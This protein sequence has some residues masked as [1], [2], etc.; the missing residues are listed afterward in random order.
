[1]RRRLL[2]FFT[3]APALLLLAHGAL[4]QEAPARR[5]VSL[6]P[7]FTEIA[8]DIGA[9]KYLVGVTDFCKFPRETARVPKVGGFL[10]LNVETVMGM[11]PDLVLALPF[12]GPKLDVL[13]RQGL[14]VVTMEDSRVSDVLD[15]Y[16]ALGRLFGME[17]EAAK[18]KRRLQGKLA[19]IQPM[20]GPRPTAL[21]VA[22]TETGSLSQMTVAGRGTF[23]HELLEQSG[24]RNVFGDSRNP[25][26][27]VSKESVLARDP[28]VIFHVL[29]E[30]ASGEDQRERLL[31]LYRGWK[32]LRAA[33]EGRVF[34]IT[35][36]E[37][38]V[39]GPTMAGLGM[40][41]MEKRRM[42]QAR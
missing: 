5:V 31:A 27:P 30:N 36:D 39:P 38:T 25:Y 7:H 13:R 22:G 24:F 2:R 33:S 32:G 26:L 19:K 29:P 42:L 9:G 20:E 4:A 17:K 11:K 28:D 40:Y 16:D 10:N 1:M 14:R 34:F 37:W 15:A 18:A 8:F 35:K 6:S 23:A 3:W 21:F 41:F 12:F